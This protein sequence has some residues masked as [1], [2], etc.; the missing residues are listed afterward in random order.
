MI[1]QENIEAL[2]KSCIPII[3]KIPIVDEDKQCDSLQY[4]KDILEQQYL[5]FIKN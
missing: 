3:T 5:D 2:S 1:C 4:I